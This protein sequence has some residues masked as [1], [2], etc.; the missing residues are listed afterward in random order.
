M[1]K[2]SPLNRG[3]RRVHYY[4]GMLGHFIT[5]ASKLRVIRVASVLVHIRESNI[6]IFYF[7]LKLNFIHFPQGGI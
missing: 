1:Q 5:G 4:T 7:M 2:D 6:N 3:A